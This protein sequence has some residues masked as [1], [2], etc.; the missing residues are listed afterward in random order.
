MNNADPDGMT[1]GTL[2]ASMF[3]PTRDF[4][5]IAGGG[6]GGFLGTGLVAA[7]INMITGA[8]PRPRSTERSD[9]NERERSDTTDITLARELPRDSDVTIYRY[10]Y[11]E[12][13]ILHLVPTEIDVR[14]NSGLS[15]STIPRP[16][17]AVTTINT[18][19]QSGFFVA[20]R[21]KPTHVAVYPVGTTL[22]VWHCEGASSFWTQ[23]L[24]LL[25]IMN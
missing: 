12:K 15:F 8:L 13:G 3:Y 14:S 18:L 24:T 20:I 6:G 16:G 17:S 2:T 23:M 1:A 22:S 25:V 4:P 9:A 10:G 7:L 11:R 5:G 21:D 19:N